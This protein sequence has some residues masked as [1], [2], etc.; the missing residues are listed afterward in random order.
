MSVWD[1]VEKSPLRSQQST[2]YH[3]T[4]RCYRIDSATLSV[5]FSRPRN[6]GIYIIHGIY[7]GTRKRRG[8]LGP[9][10]P[11][12]GAEDGEKIVFAHTNTT[13]GKYQR[14]TDDVPLCYIIGT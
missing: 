9:R 5:P 7:I 1:P 12:P 2:I 4:R 3:T 8:P 10:A 11:P 13:V 14:R 6:E